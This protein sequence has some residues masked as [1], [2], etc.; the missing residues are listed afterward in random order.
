MEKLAYQL[1]DSFAKVKAFFTSTKFLRFWDKMMKIL[2]IVVPQIAI[3]AILIA[4]SYIFMSPILR[5]LVDSAYT[6]YQK[7]G[8]GS[9]Y[10]ES[11]GVPAADG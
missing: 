4:F 3:Y 2:R 5:V 6:R 1:K 11:P 8:S 10:P 7:P 9:P